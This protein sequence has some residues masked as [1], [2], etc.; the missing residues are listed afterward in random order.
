MKKKG[1]YDNIVQVTI[2]KLNYRS[3]KLSGRLSEADFLI[4]FLKKKKLA[5]C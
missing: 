2:G 1:Y 4:F 3:M 5:F